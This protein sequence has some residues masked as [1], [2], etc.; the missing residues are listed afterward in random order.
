MFFCLLHEPEYLNSSTG[1][2]SC[3]PA[4]LDYCLIKVE[5]AGFD[6]IRAAFGSMP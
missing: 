5:M 2:G 1:P 4:I 3:C 6:G